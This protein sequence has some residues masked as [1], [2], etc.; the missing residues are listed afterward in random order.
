M[1]AVYK[2]FYFMCVC[3]EREIGVPVSGAVLRFVCYREKKTD[4]TV[5]GAAL[6]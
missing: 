1:V 3:W 4:I 2:V 5:F 6:T